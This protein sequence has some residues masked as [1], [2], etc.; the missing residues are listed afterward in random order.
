MITNLHIKNLGIIEDVELELGENFNSLTG[1]TGAGKSLIIDALC[2]ISGGRFSKEMIKKGKNE[3]FIEANIFLA[4]EE[5]MDKQNVVVSRN[6]SINGKNICKINGSIVSVNELKKY[7]ESIVDIH[8]QNDNNKLLDKKYH[9]EYVDSYSKEILS[10]KK[11][12]QS[13]YFEYLKILDELNKNLGDEKERKRTLDLLEYELNEIEEANL[14]ESEEELEN[15]HRLMQN[16]SKIID[17][18]NMSKE[19]LDEKVILGLENCIKYFSKIS[20]LDGNYAK[21]LEILQ[22]SYYDLIDVRDDCI[23]M[24]E[25]LDINEMETQNF[26]DRLDKIHSLKRKYGNTIDEIKNYKE[27]IKEKIYKI[28]NMEEYVLG[29]NKKLNETKLKMNELCD[30]LH[31]LRFEN[32]NKISKLINKELLD[33]EMKGVEIKIDI[34]T[35]DY[36]KFNIN[37]LDEVEFLIKTNVGGDYLSLIKIASGGEMARIMLGMKVVLASTYK[38][39]LTLVLDEIDTGISGNSANKVAEKLVKIS[40][41]MQVICV[42][43]LSNIAAVADSNFYIYKDVIDGDTVSKVK[44]LNNEEKTNEIARIAFGKITKTAIEYALELQNQKALA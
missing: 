10:V 33:M 26:M 29:L 14:I 31:I 19:D 5:D 39:D 12:Y 23:N 41:K 8:M 13:Y 2:L 32:G 4:N 20:D 28:N 18:L 43:H 30:K 24:L 7:M 16:S 37:G 36:E 44:L 1:D 34:N 22:N 21:K 17:S 42:T 27:E 40:K 15:K 25:N 35:L 38:E 6:I 3:L 11:E 9:I